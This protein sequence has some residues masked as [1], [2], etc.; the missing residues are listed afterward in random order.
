MLQ[1][2]FNK[3]EYQKNILQMN[4]KMLISSSDLHQHHQIV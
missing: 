3:E 2:I 4:G 1:S